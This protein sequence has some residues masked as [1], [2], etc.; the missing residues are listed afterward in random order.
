MP[1]PAAV[2]RMRLVR[3]HCLELY[4]A[5]PVES[6]GCLI[7]AARAHAPDAYILG[8]LHMAWCVRSWEGPAST[9]GP[10]TATWSPT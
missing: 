2:G 10:L 6:V 4:M 9:R 5:M 3:V 7:C 8:S 1:K